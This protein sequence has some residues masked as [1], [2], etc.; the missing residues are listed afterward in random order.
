MHLPLSLLTLL[1]PETR[2]RRAKLRTARG[3]LGEGVIGTL[4]ATAPPAAAV[5]AATAAALSLIHI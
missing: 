4:D 5:P 1:L 2:H 3:A